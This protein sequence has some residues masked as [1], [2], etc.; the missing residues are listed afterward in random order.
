MACDPPT[1]TL[2]A[3]TD[4]TG[5]SPATGYAGHFTVD[6]RLRTVAVMDRTITSY[7]IDHQD[8]D[9]VEHVDDGGDTRVTVLIDGVPLPMG[10]APSDVPD[11]DAVTAILRSWWSDG[12]GMGVQHDLHDALQAAI[13][14][15]VS[16]TDGGVRTDTLTAAEAGGLLDVLRALRR[17]HGTSRQVLADHGQVHPFVNLVAAQ[18]HQIDAVVRVLDRHGVTAPDDSWPPP[19]DRSPTVLAACERGLAT[20][21]GLSI[22]FDRMLAESTRPELISLYRHLQDAA[23]LRHVPTL[24]RCVTRLSHP[25]GGRGPGW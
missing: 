13:H 10:F 12:L 17:A 22:L 2:Q 19:T 24:R 8:V 5:T 4:Q 9:V 23:R 7:R 11:R 16:T 15:T 6:H 1:V 21:T 14:E 25:A 20:E 3:G 18:R